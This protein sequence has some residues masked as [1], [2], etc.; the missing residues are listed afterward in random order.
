MLGI[1]RGIPEGGWRLGTNNIDNNNERLIN[2][3][4]TNV[5]EYIKHINN[6][7]NKC[8]GNPPNN[9]PTYGIA[10]T[11]ATQNYT[12]VD[13]PRS[14]KIKTSQ[15]PRVILPDGSIMQATHKAELNLI[16]LL[17]TRAKIVHIFTHLQSGS[18]I[19]VG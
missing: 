10:D 9:N 2:K 8:R 1:T 12:K 15:G 16:P 18:L 11:G 6:I 13:T 4:F 3:Y 5:L 17:S 14:N 19:S 7:C